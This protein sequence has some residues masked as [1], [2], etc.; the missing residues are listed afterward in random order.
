MNHRN[1][2]KVWFYLER[3]LSFIEPSRTFTLPHRPPPPI[4]GENKQ[5]TDD[6]YL[7]AK[8]VPQS[9]IKEDEDETLLEDKVKE[10]LMKKIIIFI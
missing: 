2:M 9:L 8:E 6:V 4:P 10:Y 1:L 5:V 7:I 3:P